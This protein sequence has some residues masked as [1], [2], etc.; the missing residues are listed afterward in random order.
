MCIYSLDCEDRVDGWNGLLD[1]CR[2]ISAKIIHLLQIV[3]GADVHRLLQGFDKLKD[4]LEYVLKLNWKKEEKNQH[5]LRIL[6]KD[7]LEYV[8]RSRKRE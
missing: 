3:Y 8:L 4:L 5:I 7:L 1:A 2:I 6:L